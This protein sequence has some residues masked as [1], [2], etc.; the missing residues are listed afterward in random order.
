MATNSTT[1]ATRSSTK[2]PWRQFYKRIIKYMDSL[3][4]EPCEP[5]MKIDTFV[6]AIRHSFPSPTMDLE[7]HKKSTKQMQTIEQPR[8]IAQDPSSSTKRTANT[9]TI[10]TDSAYST[11]TESSHTPQME[12]TKFSPLQDHTKN[13]TRPST[14]SQSI[15]ILKEEISST[16]DHQPKPNTS[17]WSNTETTVKQP[18]VPA[19]RTS[20]AL[21]IPS[22]HKKNTTSTYSTSISETILQLQQPLQTIH[23]KTISIQHTAHTRAFTRPSP[24]Y[25]RFYRPTAFQDHHLPGYIHISNLFTGPANYRY[26]STRP[27]LQQRPLHA[28]FQDF[29]PRSYQQPCQGHFL[30]QVP[31]FS[32]IILATRTLYTASIPHTYF[33]TIPTTI[34]CHV[35]TEVT[36]VIKTFLL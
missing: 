22:A 25:N 27:L 28:N 17:T 21:Y 24:F 6:H 30:Q 36:H 12:N 15:T 34:L 13:I 14:S 31:L 29:I 7:K 3:H 19:T 33:P 9:E 18:T 35:K 4:A 1:M 20:S 10:D 2:C 26:Y 16:Q 32:S 5:Q 23:Y 11:E 8:R